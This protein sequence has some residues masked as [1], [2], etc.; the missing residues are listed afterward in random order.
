MLQHW[1]PLFVWYIPYTHVRAPIV[2]NSITVVV[3]VAA[4]LV[5]VVYIVTAAVL[6]VVEE[7]LAVLVCSIS[8][9]ILILVHSYAGS[10]H[11]IIRVYCTIQVIH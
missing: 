2:R 10:R 9:Y 8:T 1:G 3:I 6:V 11:L 7:V 5:L 4:L